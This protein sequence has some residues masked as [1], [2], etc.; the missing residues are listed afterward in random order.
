[1][2]VNHD[3]RPPRK[4]WALLEYFADWADPL[5]EEAAI[6]LIHIYSLNPTIA[7]KLSKAVRDVCEL[8]IRRQE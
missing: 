7:W 5:H 6:A 8:L 4:D 1:M 3:D 2:T